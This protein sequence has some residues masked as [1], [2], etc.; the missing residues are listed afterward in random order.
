MDLSATQSQPP[1]N[2]GDSTFSKKKKKIFDEHFFGSVNSIKIR[3]GH[4][5]KCSKIIS[6]LIRSRRF[7]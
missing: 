3:N 5:R 2:Q 6:N 4:S 1:R 7:N